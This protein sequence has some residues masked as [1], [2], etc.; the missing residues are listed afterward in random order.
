MDVYWI[1]IDS[2]V[3]LQPPQGGQ[4]ARPGQGGQGTPPAGFGQLDP[5]KQAEQ[6]KS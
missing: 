5:K 6:L 2:Q 3:G 4:G 1:T